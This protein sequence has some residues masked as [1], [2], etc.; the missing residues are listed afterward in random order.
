MKVSVIVPAFNE[1]KSLARTLE[2]LSNQVYKNVELIVIDN[3]STDKTNSIAKKFTKNVWIETRKGYIHAV[4]RGAQES[5]GDLITFCD[6]DTIYPPQWLEKVVEEFQKN[7]KAVG[8]YGSCKTHDA[9]PWMN[10]IAGF[11]Y[12]LFLILSRCFGMDNT[13]GFNFIM[14]RDA[15]FR[16]GGYDPNFKKMSPD[17][18]LG[19]RLKKEGPIIFN[20]QVIVLSSFRRFQHGGIIKTTLFFL[21]SWMQMLT[22]KQPTVS[23][24]EYNKEIR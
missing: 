20:H 15:F 14:K 5:K 8:F 1:E 17:I 18:E 10:N 2:S 6:A 13:S 19:K 3:N 12:T 7:P 22:G 11:F 4:S 9:S 21:K 23:Y 24:E 16:I